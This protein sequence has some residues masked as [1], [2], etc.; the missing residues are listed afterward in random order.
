MPDTVPDFSIKKVEGFCFHLHCI[1][2]EKTKQLFAIL[3]KARKFVQPEN[4]NFTSFCKKKCIWVM[5]ETVLGFHVKKGYN[6]CFDL[7]CIH[8]VELR[9]TENR[10]KKFF[11]PQM[12]ISQLFAKKTHTWVFLN[13]ILKEAKSLFFIYII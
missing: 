9:H 2:K 13:L 5:V 3:K 7:Q 1:Y 11:D 6:F 4:E 10:S 12:K 8:M